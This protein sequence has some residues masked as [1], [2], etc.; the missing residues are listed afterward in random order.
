MTEQRKNALVVPQ[1]AI[2]ELQGI[3]QV[4]VVGA[5]NTVTIRVVK[6]GPQFADM[7][8]VDSGLEPG[9]KVIVDGLQRLRDGMTVAPTPFKATQAD[10]AA[11][12]GA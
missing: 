5:D 10:A 2:A 6:L 11:R 9:D 3:Y 1:R 8:V 4:G 7:W 12:G